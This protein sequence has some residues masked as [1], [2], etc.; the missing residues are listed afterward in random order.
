MALPRIEIPNSAARADDNAPVAGASVQVNKRGSGVPA[1][2]YGSEDPGDT[3]P[4]PNPL[5][6]DAAG[7]IEG[8][9][10]PGRYTFTVS[11]VSITTISRDVDLR[12]ATA[13]STWTVT[14]LVADRTFDPTTATLGEALQVL[15]TLISDLKGKGDLT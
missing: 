1:T 6:T 3:T 11:G 7:A 2:I 13:T 10:E 14:G 9:V 8:Y 4:I 15:A 5:I 12:S